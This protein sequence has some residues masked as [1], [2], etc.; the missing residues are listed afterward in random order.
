[1]K[2]IAIFDFGSQYT[3][4]IA[5]RIRELGVLAKIYPTDIKALKLPKDVIGIILSGG[6][7]SVYDK[8]SPRVDAKIFALGL[9][10]L[11]LCYGHQLMAHTLKG[12]VRPGKIKEYGR[13]K[14]TLQGT[15]PLFAKI[16]KSSTVWM[17]HGDSVSKLP[18]EFK[19]IGSTNDCAIAAMKDSARDFY[20]LQFHPEVHHTDQG[21][22]ILNNFVFAI[23]QAKKNWQINNII[24]EQIKKIKKQV[25]NKKVFLLVSGGVDSSVAFSL[26]TKALGSKRVYGLYIDTGFMRLRESSEIRKFMKQAGF[27]NLRAHDASKIFYERLKG[28]ADPE[29]KRKIIGQT[30][31]D[32]KDVVAKKLNLDSLQWLLAQGTIYPDTIETGATK[33]ADTIKTHHNRVDAIQK[34]IKQGKVIEP[35]A[36]FYKDEV[37][38]LGTLLGLP[39]KMVNRHPFP[40]P[41]LAIRILCHNATDEKQVLPDISKVRLPITNYH[42]LSIKSVGVQ[43]D[44]RTYAH[45]LAI[46]SNKTWDALDKISSNITNATKEINR[47]LVLLN[48]TRHPL[49]IL[50]A[51]SERSVPAELK[52]LVF[53]FPNED[54]TLTLDRIKLLQKID[55]IVMQE[56]Q[57]AG[58]YDKIWQFPT[59]LIPIG[60]KHFESVVLRPVTSK[61]AMTASFARIKRHILKRITQKIL[62]TGKIDYIFYDITNKPPGTIEWE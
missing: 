45:P 10:I 42:I 19:T 21:L 43:G 2:H 28:V 25:K 12:T 24:D 33:H 9:P 27:T 52:D 46:T 59:V 61:E 38:K 37:R 14:L 17:S 57:N 44:N 31:I 16:K 8:K 48:R 7:Q 60:C 41:G 47:V 11:G 6:P 20:G 3:H 35:I 62:N 29:Q 23:C 58:L 15:S 49:G 56:I 36:D 30:F 13:A 18:K 34:L 5:R 1:M 22:K 50:G 51:G 39:S 26:L 55:N 4:L 40:G 54:R 32:V 53:N